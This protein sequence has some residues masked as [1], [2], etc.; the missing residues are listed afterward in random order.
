M[1]RPPPDPPLK[2]LGW[3]LAWL[4]DVLGLF[5][6]LVVWAICWFAAGA[7]AMWLWC[8]IHVAPIT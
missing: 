4:V 5:W 1:T 6:P 8:L 3:D 2:R 7:F